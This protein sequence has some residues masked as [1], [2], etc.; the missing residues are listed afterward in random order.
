MVETGRMTRAAERARSG[1]GPQ[2]GS[3]SRTSSETEIHINSHV[4]I[5][6]ANEMNVDQMEEVL[7]SGRLTREEVRIIRSRFEQA[8]ES[9]QLLDEV[10]GFKRQRT[11]S[12]D[13]H[14]NIDNSDS[15]SDGNQSRPRKSMDLKYKNVETLRIT[16][17]IREWTDWKDDDGA[18]QRFRS[19]QARIIGANDSMDKSCR[20]LWNTVVRDD[21]SK[22]RDW[23]YFVKGLRCKF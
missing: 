14:N 15:D 17:S 11:T 16:S 9:Q 19:D 22:A 10:R 7:A 20:S 23:V 1:T 12:N 18:P 3:H 13:E 8:K 21:P 2:T 5:P 6:P 4:N